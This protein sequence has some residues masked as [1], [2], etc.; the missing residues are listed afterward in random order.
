MIPSE[1]IVILEREQ[2]SADPWEGAFSLLTD[3]EINL[4]V[5]YR[6]CIKAGFTKKQVFGM[7]GQESFERAFEAM[8]KAEQEVQR[9]TMP[10]FHVTIKK[11]KRRKKAK[12]L[13]Y[14]VCAECPDC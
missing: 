2:S 12:E 3:D 7:M 1:H 6:E 11:Q 4:I 13:D 14:D 10:T 9:L 5:E 8:K